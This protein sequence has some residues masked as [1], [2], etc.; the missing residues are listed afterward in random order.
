VLQ[1]SFDV[2]KNR[3]FPVFHPKKNSIKEPL[4]SSIS[5]PKK[6]AS[7]NRQF[8]VLKK[9]RIKEPACLGT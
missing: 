6:T 3:W 9:T 4:V 2:S 7:K 1:G 8:W 5:P